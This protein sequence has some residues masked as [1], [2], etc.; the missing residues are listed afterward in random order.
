M[1]ALLMGS[2]ISLFSSC[3]RT[4]HEEDGETY[5]WLITQQA[6]S[7]I[8]V[9]SALGK[10]MGRFQTPLVETYD[11]AKEPYRE[12]RKGIKVEKYDSTGTIEYTLIAD[13]AI[14]F[15]NQQLWEAKGNVVATTANGRVLTTQQLFWNERTGRIYSNVDS[16]LIQKNDVI[17]GV[18]F[19]SD[20]KFEDWEIRQPVGK[21][22]VEMEPDR[23]QQDEA[24]EGQEAEQNEAEE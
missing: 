5:E 3:R 10:K 11:Y 18:G 16:K 7:L 15:V 8:V 13:Y 14:N 1:V 4:P 6:D 22:E 24:G 19:E 12:F 2:A 9:E 17:V 23:N 20:E 21:V